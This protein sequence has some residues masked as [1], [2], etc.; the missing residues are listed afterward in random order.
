MNVQPESKYWVQMNSVLNHRLETNSEPDT[1]YISEKAPPKFILPD[2]VQYFI[3]HPLHLDGQI[4]K[5]P[6]ESIKNKIMEFIRVN[7]CTDSGNITELS[8]ESLDRFLSTPVF[9]AILM[10]DDNVI[11]TMITPIFRV[12]Y[13]N[14]N[15][16]SSYTTFLCVDK[17]YRN[18]GLAMILIRAVMKE[19]YNKYKMCHGYYMTS[20][21]HHSVCNEIKS[22]YRPINI[23]NAKAAGFSLHTY[24]NQD[25]RGKFLES[26]RRQRIA[27]SI[28]KPKILPMKVTVETQESYDLIL[29]IFQTS[30]EDNFYLTPTWQELK[31]LCNCFDIYTVGNDSLF[32]LF[33]MTSLISQTRK[34]VRN[35]QVALM[36]GD[37]L[38]HAL[39]AA[40][41][42]GYDLLY[43]WCGGDIT[44]ERIN[45]IRGIITVARSYLE[46][47]NTKAQICNN[48]M[49]TPIF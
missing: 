2:G 9:I 37:V 32:M 31:W 35:A 12:Q 15:F 25:V 3:Y 33:P 20:Q 49:S 39:W 22:W 42:S 44:H 40:Y 34:R 19:G 43:G 48:N 27:Y 11:G 36:I 45:N 41:Q 29:K 1:F 18:S 38:H 16:L 13:K 4:G 26:D 47:Y 5:I 46:F 7:D 10:K 6:S 21:Q 24:Q 8:R 28:S 23:G 14:F 30:T 17:L